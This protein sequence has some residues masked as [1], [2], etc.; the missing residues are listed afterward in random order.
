MHIGF[1][2]QLFAPEV[3]ACINRVSGLCEHWH[4][5]GHE[6]TAVTA[7]PNYPTGRVAK[8]YH[9][10]LWAK[11]TNGAGYQVCRYWHWPA[12]NSGVV[13]RTVSQL[14]FASSVLVGGLWDLRKCDV[15]VVT[16]PPI[17]QALPAMFLGR[18]KN[19]PWV[20]D[21]RDPVVETAKRLGMVGDGWRY[22]CLR[23]VEGACYRSCASVVTVTKSFT[24][25]L[26]REGVDRDK[27]SLIPNG[28]DLQWADAVEIDREAVR[29]ELDM[30]DQFVVAYIGTHGV[31]QGVEAIAEAAEVLR[32]DDSISFLLV[33]D[34]ALK[35]AI[36]RRTEQRGLS[37]IRFQAPQPRQEVA[38][39]Y[40]AADLA[41]VSLRPDP[42]LENFIP[43]K[44]FEIMA[45]GRPILGAV[46]GEAREILE[47]SGAAVI[48]EPGDP[49]SIAQGIIQAKNEGHRLEE[50]GRAG[51]RFVE[52]HYD[53][54]LL[55][56]RYEQLLKRIVAE[57]V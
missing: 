37:N 27:V 1:I 9:W 56:E 42:F 48:C 32:H 30:K 41:V 26:E 49:E 24:E 17:F 33:G 36:V 20:Y 47:Q 3:G 44:M 43:S 35:E 38:K 52:K 28:A 54:K 39:L 57:S 50:R 51:R 25:M 16:S 22:R 15:L 10:K 8:E 19:T 53:R 18:L 12:P 13:K 14:S 55:A 29:A 6:I 34:G 31:T 5:N 7:Y 23:A 11:D 4:R 40:A 21:M 45:A 2:S 46:R